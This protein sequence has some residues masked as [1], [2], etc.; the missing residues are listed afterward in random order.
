MKKLIVFALIV[1]VVISTIITCPTRQAHLEA[2]NTVVSEVL[3]DMVKEKTSKLK[4]DNAFIILGGLL[5]G[6]MLES[7]ATKLTDQM[8][9]VDNFFIL[10]L[11][12]V[13]YKEQKQI[14]SVGFCGHVFTLPEDMVKKQVEKKLNEQIGK[15]G[16]LL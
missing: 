11:G 3:D 2:I 15:I 6:S 7:E 16:N 4:T 1:I 10:S 13:E 9:T 12:R 5:V 8:V 14:V